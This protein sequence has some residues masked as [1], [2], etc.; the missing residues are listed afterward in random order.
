MVSSMSD[1]RV[2]VFGVLNMVFSSPD[3]VKAPEDE[4]PAP[5]LMLLTIQWW[6]CLV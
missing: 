1:L 6:L 3:L 4:G 5:L 2:L